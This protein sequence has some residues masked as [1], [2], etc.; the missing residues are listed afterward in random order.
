MRKGAWL[1]TERRKELRG[2]G[3]RSGHMG[4][5]EAYG[6]GSQGGASFLKHWGLMLSS[7]SPREGLQTDRRRPGDTPEKTGE[8][9]WPE[10][11]T[12]ALRRKGFGGGASDCS[13]GL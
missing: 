8:A 3:A 7:P 1:C 4:L 6:G 11:V 10:G 2:R 9:L 13:P 5:M 12:E